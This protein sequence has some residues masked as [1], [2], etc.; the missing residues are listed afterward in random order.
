[1][2]ALEFALFV[3]IL[4]RPQ[5]ILFMGRLTGRDLT[6]K[7]IRA[8]QKAACLVGGIVVALDSA[9]RYTT[10]PTRYYFYGAIALA[11]LVG[12]YLTRELLEMP[13][14]GYTSLYSPRSRS[15]QQSESPPSESDEERADEGPAE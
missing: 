10:P 5:L 7:G 15:P 14:G 2:I 11:G 3:F 6:Q 4:T 9:D 8:M 13:V 1:M 12:L